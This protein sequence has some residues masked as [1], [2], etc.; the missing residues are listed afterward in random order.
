MNKSNLLSQYEVA[1]KELDAVEASKG[2]L[3][4]HRYTKLVSFASERC[5][6]LLDQLYPEA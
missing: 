5:E 6:A 1:R 4:A 3:P 2:H